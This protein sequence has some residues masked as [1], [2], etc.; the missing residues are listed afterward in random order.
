MQRQQSQHQKSF[1]QRMLARGRQ[2]AIDE[3][4]GSTVSSI[5]TESNRTI[6]GQFASSMIASQHLW[7]SLG[8]FRIIQ[9]QSQSQLHVTC[10][11]RD[12]A[13]LLLFSYR[14]DTAYNRQKATS[15]IRTLT[16]E[17]SNPGLVQCHQARARKGPGCALE[18]PRKFKILSVSCTRHY[19]NNPPSLSP[20]V[21]RRRQEDY[22][23]VFYARLESQGFCFNNDGVRRRLIMYEYGIE[24]AVSYNIVHITYVGK[25]PYLYYSPSLPY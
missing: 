7:A 11:V 8:S 17:H 15:L 12:C 18:S 9:C 14:Y 16:Y 13:S 19:R 24:V 21:F 22:S 25:A 20:F 3:R 2:R 23:V 6:T 5:F 10:A 1:A 4:R